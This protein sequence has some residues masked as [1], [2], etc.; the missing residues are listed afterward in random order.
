MTCYVK[1]YVICRVLHL[2]ALPRYKS[3]NYCLLRGDRSTNNSFLICTLVEHSIVNTAL[4]CLLNLTICWN[5]SQCSD[6]HFFNLHDNKMSTQSQSK[7]RQEGG[8]VSTVQ[9]WNPHTRHTYSH[10]LKQSRHYYFSAWTACGKRRVL[11]YMGFFPVRPS[12]PSR[13]Q[14]AQEEREKH[15]IRKKT[16]FWSVYSEVNDLKSGQ[17]TDRL[18]LYYISKALDRANRKSILFSVETKFWWSITGLVAFCSERS[19]YIDPKTH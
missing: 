16:I 9:H 13:P 10:S 3:E 14:E 2:S 7:F 8:G 6:I 5:K 17:D 19:K 1:Y 15:V 11:T 18:S 4:V 12:I